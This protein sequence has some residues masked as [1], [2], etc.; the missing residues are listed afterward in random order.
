MESKAY[1]NWELY[2]EDHPQLKDI[3]AAAE[4]QDYEEEMVTFI[5]GLFK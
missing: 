1:Q 2:L 4:L 5:L 3:E